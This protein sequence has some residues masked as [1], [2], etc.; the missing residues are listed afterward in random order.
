MFGFYKKQKVFLTKPVC[1]I[2]RKSELLGLSRDKYLARKKLEDGLTKIDKE[3]EI[4][5]FQR[6]KET[7]LLEGD[8]VTSYLCLELAVGKERT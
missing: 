6:S 5:W 1:D 2:D 7:K 8:A 4:K 3:E